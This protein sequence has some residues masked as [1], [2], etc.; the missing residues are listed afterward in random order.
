MRIIARGFVLSRSRLVLLLRFLFFEHLFFLRRGPEQPSASLSRERER[1]NLA[2]CCYTISVTN[3]RIASALCFDLFF[4]RRKYFFAR[5]IRK[6]KSAGKKRAFQYLPFFLLELSAQCV[7]ACVHACMH[8]CMRARIHACVRSF[9]VASRGSLTF[10]LSN[11]LEATT[12]SKY[13]PVIPGYGSCRL[14]RRVVL[15][16]ELI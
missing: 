12:V 14:T 5:P 9:R 4:Q 13:R 6:N 8:A 11:C 3:A 16:V 15:G 10:E 1:K 2:F 7:R